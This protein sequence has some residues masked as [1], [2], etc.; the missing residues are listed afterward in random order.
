MA[1]KRSNRL[2]RGVELKLFGHIGAK[3]KIRADVAIRIMLER[4]LKLFKP[5]K[6]IGARLDTIANP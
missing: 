4:K 3:V 2:I 5:N 6:I 1:R